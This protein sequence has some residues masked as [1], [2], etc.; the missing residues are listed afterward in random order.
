MV[1]TKNL[2]AIFAL[3]AAVLIFLTV[4][5]CFSSLDAPIFLLGHSTQAESQTT[6][7]MDA[8]CQKDWDA[9]SALLLGHPNLTEEEEP[10]S[11]LASLL[12]E[13]FHDSLSYEFTGPC[14]AS[15][16]GL[17]REVTV[18][19]L[20]IPTLMAQLKDQTQTLLDA[21]VA[22]AD[23]DL[24]YEADGTYREAFVMEVLTEAAANILQQDPPYRTWKL[25]LNLE[26]RD[27]NWQ[28]RMDQ[29]LLT[30]LSGGMG[31]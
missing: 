28:I 23:A 12:W 14:R 17:C 25:T 10:E 11:A 13:A 24:V 8:I 3:L 4:I 26:L 1:S 21:Q 31:R 20:D 15:G 29:S 22:S 9:A 30:L 18:T 16:S 6:A 5:L 19:G 27:G 2:S 7:L